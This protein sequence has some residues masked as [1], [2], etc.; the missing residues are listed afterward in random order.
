MYLSARR[1]MLPVVTLGDK[2]F[3]FPDYAPG[4]FKAGELIPGQNIKWRPKTIP[5]KA[6]TMFENARLPKM[7]QM[8]T[9]K[10]RERERQLNLEKTEVGGLDD[11]ENEILAEYRS[12]VEEE[13]GAKG[14]AKG[15]GKKK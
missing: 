7:G 13:V 9:Y 2:N 14:G 3:R 11:W 15:R 5:R 8:K 10:Q 4:F 6:G 12:P 1:N